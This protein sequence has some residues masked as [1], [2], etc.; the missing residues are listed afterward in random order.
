MGPAALRGLRPAYAGRRV[1]V[2][3]DTGF[4]GAWLCLWLERL[5]AEVWGW[6]LPPERGSLFAAAGLSRRV[7]HADGDLRDAAAFARFARRA[8]PSHLFHLGAQALVRRSY[9]SPRE[10]FEVNVMGSVSVLEAARS[11]PGLK[12]LVYCTSD[13]CYRDRGLARGFR[14][15][16]E[17]GGDDPYSASKAAAE[18]VFGSYRRVLLPPGLGAVAVRAG[19]VIGGGDWA[20]DRIVP[21]IARAFAGGR[22][23]VLR[24]PEAVRPWQHVLDPLCGY[25]TAGARAAAAPRRFSGA[26]NFGPDARAA[27][28]VRELVEEFGRAWGAAPRVR[29]ERAREHETRFLRLDPGK[30]RRELGWRQRWGFRR[31]VAETA[32]WY[33]AA[34]GGADPRRLCLDQIA[35]YEEGR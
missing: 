26:W 18:V 33:R 8:R 11:I 24:R 32:R 34:A 13:K 21:D 1:L 5:G 9:R 17:L 20:E 7:R 30:A 27:R 2:T 15:D 35:A 14:E 16:D 23:L 12:A 3:G 28:T 31:A 19:N 10:T 29:L 4:K 25:L 22:P 6:A